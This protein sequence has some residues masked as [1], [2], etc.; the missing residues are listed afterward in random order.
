[1]HKR[2]AMLLAVFTLCIAVF[3]GERVY[4]AVDVNERTEGDASV[5]GEGEMDIDIGLQGEGEGS[6]SATEEESSTKPSTNNVG[7]GLNDKI[8]QNAKT[9]DLL[10]AEN[11]TTF[12]VVGAAIVFVMCFKQR[13]KK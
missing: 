6:S 12:I 2:L 8:S 10:S 1:M 5:S 11:V 9:G 7:T 13:E 4:A 3:Q